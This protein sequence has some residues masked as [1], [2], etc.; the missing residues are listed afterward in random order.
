[1]AIPAVLRHMT[2]SLGGGL[3]VGEYEVGVED[4][5]VMAGHGG[6]LVVVWGA[7]WCGVGGVR[8]CD[9]L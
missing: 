6:G 5:R 4:L 1:M 3:V 8:S 7:L 9:G 2:R